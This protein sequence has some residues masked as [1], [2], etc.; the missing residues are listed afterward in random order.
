M[1]TPTFSYQLLVKSENSTVK[2]SF[3]QFKYALYRRTKIPFKKILT[4]D[5]DTVI[6]LV[7]FVSVLKPTKSVKYIKSILNTIE[8]NEIIKEIRRL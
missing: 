7:L 4:I 2:I 8:L 6:N 5:T 3:G 1:I